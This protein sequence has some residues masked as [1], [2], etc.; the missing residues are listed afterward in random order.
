VIEE[1]EVR[2]REKEGSAESVKKE[3]ERGKKKEVS[4]EGRGV[5]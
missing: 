4:R 5:G 2:M 3:E 1:R